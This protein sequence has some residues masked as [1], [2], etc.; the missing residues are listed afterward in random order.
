MAGE[1]GWWCAVDES[2]GS[3]GGS[4]TAVERR[5]KW[6]RPRRIEMYSASA[7]GGARERK[8]K[9]RRRWV[10][11]VGPRDSHKRCVCVRA[12]WTNEALGKLCNDTNGKAEHQVG[13]CISGWQCG[14]NVSRSGG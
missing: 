12:L 2:P 3:G 9:G 6:R 8:R 14:D 7:S 5:G 13:G 11:N 1:C 10:A 4:I